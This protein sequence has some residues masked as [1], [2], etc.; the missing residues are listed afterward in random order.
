FPSISLQCSE[1]DMNENTYFKYRK[2]LLESGLI[3]ITKRRD[4]GAKFERNIYSILAVQQPMEVKKEDEK[5]YPNSSGMDEKALN[6]GS[7]PYPN[8]SGMVKP[9]MVDSGT[10][11]N[12]SI[13][14]VIDTKDTKDTKN[15]LSEIGNMSEIEK[16]RKRKELMEK[17]YRQNTTKIPE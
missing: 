17:A 9:R 13:T 7:E 4:E 10:N 11:S 3:K 2:F 1:L 12:S 15:D 14:K 8:S 16:L 6:Q 5:P